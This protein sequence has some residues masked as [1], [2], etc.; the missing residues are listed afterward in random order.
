MSYF[1]DQLHG[2]VPKRKHGKSGKSGKKKHVS[3]AKSAD[4][5]A[6]LDMETDPFDNFEPELKILPF[7]AVLY[8]PDVEP[9][10]IWED[11]PL[12][13]EFV[14][15]AYKRTMKNG[16][17]TWKQWEYY[18][19][20]KEAHAK[21]EHDRRHAACKSFALRVRTAIEQLPGRYVIYAHNGGNF[22]F[23]FLL[24]EIRGEVLFKGRGLMRATIGR[25][26]LRDSFNIIPVSLKK[27]NR[28]DD[29]DYALMKRDKRDA[30]RQKIIDYCIADCRY[31]YEL[32]K[33]FIDN[34]GFKISIGQAAMKELK[35]SYEV[36][37]I[38]GYIDALLRPYYHGG[39][40]ECLQGAGLFSGDFSLFDV[41]SMYPDAMRSK[42]HPIGNGGHY[43]FRS[44]APEINEHTVFITLECDNRG[45]LL[46]LDAD[47]NLT[48]G[49]GH[50]I[51]WTTIHEYLT[52]QRLGLIS[53]IKLIK[54]VDC[55]LQTSF[56]NFI[57]P[58]YAQRR[59]WIKRLD[60]G[61]FGTGTSEYF[62]AE[63]QK[64]FLK[65]LMNNAYGKFAQDP[66]RFKNW[67]VTDPHG[68]VPPDVGEKP[69]A[70]SQYYDAREDGF[71]CDLRPER[72]YVWTSHYKLEDYWLWGRPAIN[73]RGG[74]FY[75]VGTAA[76]I[77]GAARAR[78]MEAI[79][80]AEDAI[81]CDTDSLL[82][83]S[84]NSISDP[85]LEGSAGIEIDASKLGAWKLEGEFC[86][87]YIAG[88]K[89]YAFVRKDGTAKIR[90]KGGSV[91]FEEMKAMVIDNAEISTINKGVTIGK[92]GSQTY[93]KRTA[94]ATAKKANSYANHQPADN[95]FSQ[96]LAVTNG[97]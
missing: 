33:D 90:H 48:S 57:D 91:S 24:P 18:H 84:L 19:A 67:Y 25:H 77:T 45:A 47:R 34:H 15:P 2:L 93:I 38:G 53:N 74:G 39:R 20:K 31:L 37:N 95:L 72:P 97:N 23:L 79:H 83:R 54:T 8:L 51:F 52:A 60:A 35:K 42:R 6:I 26:E 82:C 27:A 12:P 62:A 36:R 75:N 85:R 32:V 44:T 9:L 49:I 28:K 41:N 30:H 11:Y 76:S 63:R 43:F 1:S 13:T 80:Y 78:L 21:A 29:I 5:I 87:A 16:H 40:V 58:L 64:L 7:L 69:E 50:G 89:S 73:T 3:T 59:E 94:R 65:L 56:E 88:K 68:E 86:E 96:D 4:M 10:V 71:A 14:P 17:R 22:D 66:S 81:Y 55:S 70:K 61:E 92:D 46:G